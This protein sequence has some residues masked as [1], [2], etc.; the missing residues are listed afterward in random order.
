[1]VTTTVPDGD[2]VVF[3]QDFTTVIEDA[4]T[5][6]VEAQVGGPVTVP[7][8]DLE[9][10]APVTPDA[11]STLL[12]GWGDQLGLYGGRRDQPSCDGDALISFLRG[13]P[14]AEQAWS[15]AQG[16]AAV[17]LAG[18]LQGLTPVLLTRDTRV[19]SHRLTGGVATPY[20]TVL[21]AGLAVLIDDVGVPRVDC[22]TGNPLTPHVA[23]TA[24]PAWGGAWP[25]FDPT[26]VVAV[27]PAE[28]PLYEFVLVDVDTGLP[29]AR[30][31]GLFGPDYDVDLDR[32]CAL[33]PEDPACT[34]PP[35]T[36]T[37]TLP[38][39]PGLAA[40]T[41]LDAALTECGYSVT[42]YVD[43]GWVGEGYSVIAI[44]SMGEAEFIVYSSDYIEVNDQL[45]ADIAVECGFYQP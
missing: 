43:N 13:D 5:P 10:A 3:L 11:G 7:L 42:E 21:R 19:T 26:A 27:L 15:A 31:L 9:L 20:Q 29:F 45:A 4:F 6:G 34:E 39:D 33:V 1:V 44:T 16:I 22:A 28:E 12:G 24:A 41:I 38:D 18:Y 17:D 35:D 37:T 30:A 25:G 32:W 23:T 36:T 2:G 8:P 14:V 40:I